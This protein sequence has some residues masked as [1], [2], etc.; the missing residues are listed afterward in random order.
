MFFKTNYGKTISIFVS[1]LYLKLKLGLIY[2]ILAFVNFSN[3]FI[4]S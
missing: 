4:L 2:I 3:F 1:K